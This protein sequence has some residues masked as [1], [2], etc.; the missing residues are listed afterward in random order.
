MWVVGGG[1]WDGG[2][3]GIDNVADDLFRR[4]EGGR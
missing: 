4:R 2:K 1:R 3:V